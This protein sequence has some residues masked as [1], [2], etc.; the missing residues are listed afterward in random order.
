MEL[1]QFL[2]KVYELVADIF[3]GIVALAVIVYLLMAIMVG[4]LTI[5]GIPVCL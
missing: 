2:H 3:K 4:T 1:K 5:F